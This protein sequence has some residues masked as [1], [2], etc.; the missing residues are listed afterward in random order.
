VYFH[1]PSFDTG[2]RP[3]AEQSEPQFIHY[4]THFTSM[5]MHNYPHRSTTK[6]ILAEDRL[7]VL[8]GLARRASV[9]A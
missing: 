8:A 3:F 6:R 2:I 9:G 4:G 7:A 1:E 5:F